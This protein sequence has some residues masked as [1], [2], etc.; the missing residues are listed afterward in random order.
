MDEAMADARTLLTDD[1][2]RLEAELAVATGP[3]RAVAVL[4]H[5]HPQYGGSMRSIVIGALFDALPPRGVTCLRFNFRGVEGS[6]G[7]HDGGNLE[8]VDVEAA[9][10]A[11]DP[12]LTGAA[13]PVPLLLAGWSFGADMAL[14]VRDHRVGAWMAV[15]PPLRYVHDLDGLADDPRPKLLA[16]AQHDEVRDPAE[17]EALAGAWANTEV[18]LVGGASH[19][20]VGRTERLVQLAGAFVDRLAAPAGNA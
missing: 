12:Q 1:G 14:S 6:E 7:S 19:F 4:C 18:H 2:V 20:F 3:V 16:L 17:V 9:V 8:R 11:V 13:G 10:A 5:P 15:A